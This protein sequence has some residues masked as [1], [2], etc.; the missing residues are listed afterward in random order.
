VSRGILSPRGGAAALGDQGERAAF[1]ARQKVD[2]GRGRRRPQARAA[3]AARRRRHLIAWTATVL[4]TGG[5]AAG[6]H[7][8]LTSPRF[9]VRAVEVRGT[10]RLRTEQVLA[11]AGIRPGTN[12]WR[13]DPTA[14]IA[15]V[16]ALA[17]IRRAEMVRELPNRVALQVEE[18]RPFTLVS[19]GRLHWLDEEGRLLGE[20]RRAVAP[21]V[22]VISGLTD[23]EIAAMRRAPSAR[24]DQ[25]IA[26]IRTLLRTGST[27]VSEISE[28]DVSRHEG[29]VLYTVDGIEVRLG[30]EDWDARLARLQ[31]VLGQVATRPDTVRTIDLR[32]RDQVVLT[33]GGAG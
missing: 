22:P 4:L 31:G 10:S 15:R 7:W 28:I 8:L 30:A 16:E 2:A 18:R 25:A 5:L 1:I 19:G 24:A 29:P 6:V 23:E 32:F 27:L 17:E 26:L 13:I 33:K 21:P 3:R 20:A 12:L 11:A 14:V 9:A